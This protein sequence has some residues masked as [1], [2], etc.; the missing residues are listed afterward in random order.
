MAKFKMPPKPKK[1]RIASASVGSLERHLAK[2]KEW[3]KKCAAV[4]AEKKKFAGLVKK[5]NSIK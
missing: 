2:V 3:E 1:P 5:V 4:T